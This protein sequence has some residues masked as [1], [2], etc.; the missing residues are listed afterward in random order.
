MLYDLNPV[1]NW[2]GWALALAM[3]LLFAIVG[4]I[5]GPEEH[6]A[7]AEAARKIQMEHIKQ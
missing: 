5:D 7:Y 6:A 1:R 2:R 4:S 3:L